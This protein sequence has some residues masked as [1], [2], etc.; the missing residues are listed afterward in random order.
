MI[1]KTA[2]K[3]VL[4]AILLA[5]L[6]AYLLYF[7][8]PVAGGIEFLEVSI[9]PH[10][11]NAVGVCF[12]VIGLLCSGCFHSSRVSPAPSPVEPSSSKLN[13]I[14]TAVAVLSA[15]G[16][17]LSFLTWRRYGIDL[18]NFTSA[19][20]YQMNVL[21]SEEGRI[22]EGLPGRMVS[23]S[24]LGVFLTSYMI[25]S[26]KI[27][28]KAGFLC[29][30]MFL[31]FLISPRRGALISTI[32]TMTAMFMID[33]TGKRKSSRLLLA[34]SAAALFFAFG[35]T[36]FL[37]NKTSQFSLWASFEVASS[38]VTSNFYV[39]DAL[40]RTD[41]FTSTPILSWI[42][43]LIAARLLGYDAGIDLSIPFV[44]LPDPSNTVSAFYYFYKSGDFVA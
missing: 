43:Q 36:Q 24:A 38:Y 44:Y 41:H 17:F 20:L 2:T 14:L 8:F 30:L 3:I 4:S 35:F 1:N 40:I 15:T 39:M 19:T 25:I 27:S 18:L 21:Y 31:A 12:M 5:W 6:P 22:L 9:L 10:T 42:P 29:I 13:T 28:S 11:V 33:R 34:T 26:G 23:L 37:L 16:A 32:A 7:F